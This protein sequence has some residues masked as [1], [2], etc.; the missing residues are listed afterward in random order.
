MFVSDGEFRQV[1]PN[2]V[3]LDFNV[4]VLLT[5]VDTD[6]TANH[7]WNDDHVPEVGLHCLWL[8]AIG[9][10]TLRLPQ[11]LQHRDWGTLDATAELTTL[12]RPE[13]LHEILIA[14]I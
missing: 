4:D 12:A 10:L 1:M 9:G 11:L 5:I 3:R 7:L 14:V 6:N 13:K 8:L 2:H